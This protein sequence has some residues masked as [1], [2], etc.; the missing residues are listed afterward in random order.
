M[1]DTQPIPYKWKE[2][3]SGSYWRLRMQLPNQENHKEINE[4]LLSLK[5]SNYSKH[6]ILSYR[7]F[8]QK[9]FKD[10]KEASFS[11]TSSQI[12]QWFI[13]NE[14]DFQEAT[15]KNHLIILS[16]FYNFCVEEGTINK[17]PIK[18]RMFPRPRMAIP[19]YLDK[20]EVAKIREKTDQ[21]WLRDRCIF[22]F[23]YTSGCRV[24]EVHRL[25][26]SDV[27]LEKRMAM[28]L[29]KGKKY[30]QVHFSEK[31]ANLLELYIERR[32]D[33]NPALLVT[34]NQ[35]ANRLSKDMIRSILKKLGED[36]GISGSLHPHRLRHTYAT[37]MLAK[38]ADLLFIADELGHTD[39]QT[40]QIYANLPKQ[41]LISLY[42]KYMG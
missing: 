2:G 34:S 32:M 37:E 6:T 20:E 39:V 22:E 24:D 40:T 42:R 5:V 3:N 25:D 8:L 14:K 23:L 38:G 41:E 13:Q 33:S 19:K 36:A 18:S 11:L 17:S 7:N 9:F 10:R 4:F 35:K 29:G 30:R 27:D 31:C 28:V 26:R 16:T 15:I 21:L 12:Q 1:L